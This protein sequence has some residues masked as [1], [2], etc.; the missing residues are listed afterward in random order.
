MTQLSLSDA[1]GFFTTNQMEFQVTLRWAV[2]EQTS[3]LL[4]RSRRWQPWSL[5]NLAVPE[6]P[7][8]TALIR[9]L[10]ASTFPRFGGNTLSPISWFSCTNRSNDFL[11]PGRPE[12]GSFNNFNSLE[13]LLTFPSPRQ[14]LLIFSF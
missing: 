7:C 8:P 2:P 1:T 12:A 4:V 11:K 13:S 9:G 10:L 6:T 3:Q 14:R 5:D